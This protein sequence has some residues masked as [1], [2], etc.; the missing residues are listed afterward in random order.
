MIATAIA[1]AT[2]STL[3][4]APIASAG[5]LIT[6]NAGQVT[7]IE[8]L[9]IDGYGTYDVTFHAGRFSDIFDNSLDPGTIDAD[10]RVRP[11]FFGDRTGATA[12]AQAIKVALGLDSVLAASS[13][14]S[15]SGDGFA[16]AFEFAGTRIFNVV[17]DLVSSAQFDRLTRPAVSPSQ[18][19]GGGGGGFGGISLAK[20]TLADSG[21][22]TSVPEPSALL[23]L[24]AA[25]GLSTLARRRK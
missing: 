16:L 2:L 10:G 5:T 18:V 15:R 6:D 20:F 9:F 17:G 12:T 1:T 3:T 24:T 25:L 11:T 7:S 21:E 4:I 8:D 13:N 19:F 14:P 23:G 22:T